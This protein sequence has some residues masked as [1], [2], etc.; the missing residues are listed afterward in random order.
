MIYLLT[1]QIQ[2]VGIQKIIFRGAVL[3]VSVDKINYDVRNIGD[4]SYF[5]L[6]TDRHTVGRVELYCK[7]INDKIEK[8]SITLTNNPIELMQSTITKEITP[9]VTSSS[10]T[11]EELARPF[12]EVDEKFDAIVSELRRNGL[13][14]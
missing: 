9:Y 10:L 13:I 1:Q 12:Y 3:G 2:N 11:N 4:V 6:N 5:F 14:V 8:L 7:N